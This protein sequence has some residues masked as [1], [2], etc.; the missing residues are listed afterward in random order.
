MGSDAGPEGG[1][2]DG[3]LAQKLPEVLGS[4]LLDGIALMELSCG[5]EEE[6]P[7]MQVEARRVC[8]LPPRTLWIL[9]VVHQY[10]TRIVSI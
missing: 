1:E 10:S 8:R 4:P 9:E 6:L 7:R 5:A 3:W 2:V